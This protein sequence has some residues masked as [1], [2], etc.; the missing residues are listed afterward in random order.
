MRLDELKVN[1]VPGPRTKYFEQL[2][3]IIYL[4]SFLSAIY[5]RYCVYFLEHK[6]Y[7]KVKKL[8]KKNL[9]KLSLKNVLQIY[10]LDFTN[11]LLFSGYYISN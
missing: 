1:F 2:F 5:K 4:L 10:C 7:L 11:I 3:F 6:I 8:F 9:C